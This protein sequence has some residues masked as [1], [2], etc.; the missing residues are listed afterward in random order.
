[1][2]WFQLTEGGVGKLEPFGATKLVLGNPFGGLGSYKTDTNMVRNIGF[3]VEN[4]NWTKQWKS[5]IVK[6]HAAQKKL[7]NWCLGALWVLQN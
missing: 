5:I 6:K 1:M 3:L 2:S 4:W 7:Q